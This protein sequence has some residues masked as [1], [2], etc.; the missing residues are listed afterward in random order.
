M[1]NDSA[2]VYALNVWCRFH[3]VD[4]GAKVGFWTILTVSLY[5]VS[6]G[7]WQMF[8]VLTKCLETHLRRLPLESANW[9]AVVSNE[10]EKDC[11]IS[12]TKT[13]R[14][15][16][17]LDQTIETEGRGQSVS[18]FYYFTTIPLLCHLVL[19]IH[20]KFLLFH[21]DQFNLLSRCFSV[22]FL[23]Y[24]VVLYIVFRFIMNYQGEF[25]N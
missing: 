10:A 19:L 25:T 16:W 4:H 17:I 8:V 22:S 2:T 12:S 14:L 5:H 21:F 1:S 23:S 7:C 15:S 13:I 11:T 18:R 6:P 3:L 9:S 24:F 20:F